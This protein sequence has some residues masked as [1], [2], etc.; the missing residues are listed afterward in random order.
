MQAV[1]GNANAPI[2]FTRPMTLDAS[3]NVGIGT[4]SPSSRLSIAGAKTNSA[5]LTNAANQLTITDTTATAA[6]VGGRIS[7]LGS[8]TATPDYITFGAIEVL[9]DNANNYGSASWNNAAMRFIV[10]N[11]DNDANAGRMLERMRITSGGNV[12]IGTTGGINIVSGW[13]N[14]TVNGSTTGLV[15]IKANEVDYGAMY[16]ST[17]NNNFVVQAYGA[18]NNGNMVFLTASTERMRIQNL[19]SGGF[20][21]ATSNGSLFV[22]L[23]SPYHE[24]NNSVNSNNTIFNSDAGS[25]NTDG[26]VRIDALRNTTNNSFYVL[27]YYN[28]G[29]GTYRFRVA[30]SGNVTNT[31]GSYGALSDIKLKENITDATPKLDDLLKVK[32]RNYNLIGEETKQIGV[33]AQELEEV[34]PSMVDQS[35]DFEEVEITDEEGNTTKERQPTGTTTKS[36]K[37]SVFVPMLIKAIQELKSENDNLKSR[38]EV[39]EQS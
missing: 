7:F 26:I 16:A 11:N 4:N 1:S 31:N 19:A 17:A 15:G 9:K 3:G 20:L 10:G 29:S 5:D 30:D 12:G 28:G 24:F 18:S 21:K 23:S 36:V 33:I 25:L 35:A 34:F 38:L 2:T 32:V 13:T 37:Y 27:T 8:Y 6:G 14:L 22:S 39:L